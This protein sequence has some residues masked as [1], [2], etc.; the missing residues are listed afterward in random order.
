MIKRADGVWFTMTL[1]LVMNEEESLT[2]Q[3]TMLIT[4]RCTL[5]QSVPL[6]FRC[7]DSSGWTR[8]YLKANWVEPWTQRTDVS[9][10]STNADCASRATIN[11]NRS[12]ALRVQHKQGKKQQKG[13]PADGIRQR[14][15]RDNLDRYHSWRDLIT[16]LDLCVSS[17][18]CLPINR[19]I[20]Q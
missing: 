1:G 14:T 3:F 17:P 16:L 13:R 9:R 15:G 6:R 19:H 20:T 11:S 7:G 5:T 8:N 4:L 18:H 2:N 10:A 12:A